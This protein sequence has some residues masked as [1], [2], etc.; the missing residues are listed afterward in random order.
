[1]KIITCN[2]RCFGADDG[3]D[4]WIHRKD[5]CAQTIRAQTPDLIGF[6]EVWRQQFDDLLPLFPEYAHY[7]LADE[8]QTLHPMNTIFYR[9]DAFDLVSQGGYWLSPTP[10][11]AGSW[12]W[13]SACVRLAAWVRLTDK[14]GREFRFV[15]THLDHVGQQ[16]RENQARI[17]NEDAT[18]Y[19]EDYPQFLT[20]D[21]NCAF[22]NP[23]IQTFVDGGWQD[24]YAQIHGA[25]DPGDTFH[26]FKGPDFEGNPGKIDW[27]FSRGPGRTT[28][29]EII[30]DHDQG[31]Y[32]SDHYFVT[33][34]VEL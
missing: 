18:A 2:I 1:M 31:R 13:D 12:G 4:N 33:A 10:H 23:A 29:A 15:N 20:G 5:Y 34:E 21:M 30:R 19:P 3:A 7:A 22:S 8:A 11:V 6:Q 9:R 17:I 14:A 26:G 32:P 28:S 24:T 16:A 27:V 25:D